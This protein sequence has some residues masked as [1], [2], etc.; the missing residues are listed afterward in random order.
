MT[1]GLSFERGGATATDSEKVFYRCFGLSGAA[2][3][4]QSFPQSFR[5]G[6]GHRLSGFLDDGL[7]ELV[8][9]RVLDVERHFSSLVEID[10]PVII[11]SPIR[12]SGKTQSRYGLVERGGRRASDYPLS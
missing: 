3:S 2:N 12:V 1:N 10:M 5:N 11:M 8:R 4:G 7:S 9:F 6:A